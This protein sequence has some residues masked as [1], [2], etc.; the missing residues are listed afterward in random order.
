MTSTTSQARAGEDVH[1]RAA[2]DNDRAV[3]FGLVMS[4]LGV[5]SKEEVFPH[6][7]RHVPTL[8]SLSELSEH[9][10]RKKQLEEFERQLNRSKGSWWNPLSWF[11][12]KRA[13]PTILDQN[14]PVQNHHRSPME[15][16]HLQGGDEGSSSAND[17]SDSST[18][19][20][21]TAAATVPSS[22]QEEEKWV[23]IPVVKFNTRPLTDEEVAALPL[24]VRNQRTALLDAEKDIHKMMD[25]IEKTR[26]R[27]LRT[28]RAIKCETEIVN[29][30][31]C[32]E[33]AKKAGR[34]ESALR[35]GMMV[36][37]LEKCAAKIAYDHIH[38]EH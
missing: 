38:A 29:V 28:S 14:T 6:G 15:T 36:D 4:Q 8:R 23:D 18:A 5:A 25:S 27:Y 35:C 26:L 1:Q 20:A 22:S 17:V 19:A 32:Y 11:G 34:Q 37:A 12:S 21:D 10:Y 24:T 7:I 9:R 13:H 30:I 16:Q 31:A 33:D 3:R 2:D